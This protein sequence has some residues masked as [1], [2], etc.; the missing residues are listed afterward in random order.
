MERNGFEKKK[1]KKLPVPTD[2]DVGELTGV[3]KLL[4]EESRL[5]DTMGRTK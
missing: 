1:K 2:A 3:M 4:Y 5:R